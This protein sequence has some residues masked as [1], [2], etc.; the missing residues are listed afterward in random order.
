[1]LRFNAILSYV[2]SRNAD[3]SHS[4]ARPTTPPEATPATARQSVAI[5]FGDAGTADE[6]IIFDGLTWTAKDSGASGRQFNIDSTAALSAAAFEAAFALHADGALY[7]SAVDGAVVTLTKVADTA[8]SN[9]TGTFN[10]TPA[11]SPALTAEVDPAVPPAG[12]AGVALYIDTSQATTKLKV[13]DAFNAILRALRRDS[14]KAT[15]P[16]QFPTATTVE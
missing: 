8:I 13:W 4:I 1:M 12:T 7:G 3:N 15:A 10:I 9:V 16:A 11:F 5:T 6:T 14:A 2:A